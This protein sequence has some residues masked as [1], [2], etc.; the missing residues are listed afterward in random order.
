MEE[1]S[2]FIAFGAGIGSFLSPCVLPLVPVYLG[3][4]AGV[5]SLTPGARRWPPFLHAICFVAGFSLVFIALGASAG[6]IGAAI[7][8]VWLRKIAG[9]L[10]V[11]F[12]LFLIASQW[13]P[14]LNYEKRLE[15]MPGG[16]G[17]LRSILVGAI[18][19]LGW[20]PCIGPILG[21]ILSL[22]STSQTAW[23]G[24]Y[25]LAAYSLGLGVPFL[26]AGLALGTAL[27]V[28]RWLGRHSI[29]IALVSGLLLIAVG[30]LML[31][32]TLVFLSF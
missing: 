13:V 14:W 12:G 3:N 9:S 11:V 31:T 7:S 16:T 5:S 24:V 17:Y 23:K 27:P 15:R 20:T 1:T 6:L 2:I 18:F 32:D 29:I 28:I 25:L 4:L 10:L 22:A 30:L 19:S 21:G 26:A 8:G